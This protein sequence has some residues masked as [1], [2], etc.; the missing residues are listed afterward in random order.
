MAVA[1]LNA[2]GD[3]LKS[4]G[5]LAESEK[6]YYQALQMGSG[7]RGQ[8]SP[9]TAGI[10]SN[11]AELRLARKDFVNAQ[12]LALTGLD[13]A[14]KMVNAEGQILCYLVLAQVEHLEGN[15][16][17]ALM[18]LEKAKNDIGLNK[19]A[20]HWLFDFRKETL[21]NLQNG[22]RLFFTLIPGGS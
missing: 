18:T 5:K 13:L 6:V 19:T 14:K 2:T 17:E 7:P 4:Q 20:V 8:P 15:S 16:D 21:L 1:A 10:H 22:Y 11:L 9:I 3:I 12:Q